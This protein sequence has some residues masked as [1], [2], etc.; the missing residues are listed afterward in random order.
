LRRSTLDHWVI[1]GNNL[2]AISEID[3]QRGAIQNL[4]L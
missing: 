2:A 4:D 3:N 1:M